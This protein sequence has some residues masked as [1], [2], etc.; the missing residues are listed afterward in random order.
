VISAC[1][2]CELEVVIK[3]FS[4]A[5]NY[6]NLVI[7]DIYIVGVSNKNRMEIVD[8]HSNLGAGC[9]GLKL[10]VPD[11]LYEEIMFEAVTRAYEN[12]GVN[13]RHDIRYFT[14]CTEDC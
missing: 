13:P 4:F 2:G 5:D 14:A 6:W 10:I 7:A 11:M 8:R 9:T 3:E 1:Y 12:S